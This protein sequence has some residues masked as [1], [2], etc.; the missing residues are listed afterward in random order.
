M[1]SGRT[2]LI[3]LAGDPIGHTKGYAE[4]AA[5][6]A[7]AGHDCA[8]LP[9][10]VPAGRL[11]DFLAG[12]VHLRNLA[13]VVCTIPHKQDAARIGRCDTAARRAG[14]ANL[15]RPD[16]AGG[17][18]ASMVDGAGFLAAASAAGLPLARR[19]VQLL[20]AGGAGRAVAMAIAGEG[21][22]ALAIHDP[23][24]VR[25]ESLVGAVAAEFPGVPVQRHLGESEVLVNCSAIGMG[26]DD[27]LPCDAALIPGFVYD[28]V[29]RA[30]TPLM[31]AARA[32]GAV[33]DH[34]Y[35]MMA[36]QI[37]LVLRWMLE[38]G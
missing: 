33:A 30:D 7:A 24:A 15:L 14:S 26:S 8:Y 21:P 35:S 34:G 6:I 22:A 32:R 36:A 31:V 1:I 27:R 37:P 29:N 11:E 19:R 13:G 16:G 25:A 28:V 4:Y 18:E 20:G 12:V 38:R 17:W 2:R 10:H 23:D 5:A 9:A 3:L